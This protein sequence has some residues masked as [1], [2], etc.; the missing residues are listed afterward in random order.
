MTLG[1]LNH[2]KIAK[3]GQ[4]L[5][6]HKS[7]LDITLKK[8]SKWPG[9]YK[10]RTPTTKFGM[11]TTNYPRI[12]PVT[13]NSSKL[14][15][16]MTYLKFFNFA[17]RAS[18]SKFSKMKKILR[19]SFNQP[20]CPLKPQEIF[21]QNIDSPG[22]NSNF[23]LRSQKSEILTNWTFSLIKWLKSVPEPDVPS[24]PIQGDLKAAP[25]P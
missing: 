11:W 22:F 19:P 4:I 24:F 14:S 1:R 25:R 7:Y 5:E 6:L 9:D 12:H 21:L 23:S 18:K 2:G 3:F 15:T 13:S 20:I 16:S 8:G 10:W 17:S